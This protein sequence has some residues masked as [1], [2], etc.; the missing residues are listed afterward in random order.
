MHGMSSLEYSYI[1]SELARSLVGK[2]FG[3]IRKLGERTYRMKIGSTEVVCELGVRMH[4]TRYMEESETDKFTE[5]INK[6]LDNA[7]LI[8]IQQINKDRIVSFVFDKAS[9]IFEMFSEGN[10]ILVCDGKIICAHRYESWSDREIKAGSEYKPPKTTPLEKLELNQ[11]YVIVTLM[12]MPLGKQYALEALAKA[13]I[14]E[15]KQGD[16]LTKEEVSKLERA[17]SDIKTNA[18]PLV[19]YDK[20]KLVEF[21]LAPLSAYASLEKKEFATM[22]EAADEYYMHAEK[23]NPKLD[24]LLKRLEKQEERLAE[25]KE[26]EKENKA[27]GDLIYERYAEV[28]QAL[29]IAKSGKG[30]LD[31][32]EKSVEMTL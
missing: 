24:K 14:D 13:G 32:K 2:H 9:V 10:A 31:K 25:L 29:K 30:K 26:E 16:Q 3:R 19:F 1:I 21:A 7:K 11:K 20:G 22:S 12:K 17:I 4:A 18:K 23:P 27:K 6:E 5:K 28:E 15:K 8:A